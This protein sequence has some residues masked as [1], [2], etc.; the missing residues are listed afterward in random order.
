MPE[1]R[2]VCRLASKLL[3]ENII[4]Q[5]TRRE[6]DAAR[7]AEGAEIEGDLIFCLRTSGA[8]VLRLTERC[9]QQQQ[10][11]QILEEYLGILETK[12]GSFSTNQPS[13]LTSSPGPLASLSPAL[14]SIPRH[15]G[16]LG[17]RAGGLLVFRTLSQEERLTWDGTWKHLVFC[18]SASRA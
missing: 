13:C 16:K 6:T 18:F 11:S 9:C 7:D 3:E 5:S 8:G 2:E 15:G 1:Q 4:P 17:P 14:H 12:V 10:R